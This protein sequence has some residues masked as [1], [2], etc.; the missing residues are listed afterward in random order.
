MMIRSLSKRSLHIN[1]ATVR[2]VVAKKT[3]VAGQIVKVAGSSVHVSYRLT[4]PTTT[5]RPLPP[6]PYNDD[7]VLHFI[8]ARCPDAA[9]LLPSFLPDMAWKSLLYWIHSSSSSGMVE[10]P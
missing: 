4:A 3:R 5:T 2:L 1:P 10:K 6:L 7:P 8:Q 9:L